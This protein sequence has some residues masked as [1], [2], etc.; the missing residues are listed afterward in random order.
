MP[1]T[2]ASSYVRRAGT[3]VWRRIRRAEVELRFHMVQ[4][5]AKTGLGRQIKAAHRKLDEVDDIARGA[6]S[7]WTDTR[8]DTR[9][10]CGGT[11]EARRHLDKLG[12][13]GTAWRPRVD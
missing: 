8:A 5:R 13:I 9:G 4:R 1:P 3:S 6:R 10:V 12:S 7:D 2:A 11:E